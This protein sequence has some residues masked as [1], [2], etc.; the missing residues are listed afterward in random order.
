[1]KVTVL[2]LFLVPIFLINRAQCFL[3]K[4]I[5]QVYCYSE[6]C[7]DILGVPTNATTEEIRSSYHKKMIIANHENDAE[8][9]KRITR[10]FKTLT[11]KRTKKYYDY[12]LEKPNS[13]INIA[14]FYMYFFY[15]A[16]YSLLITLLLLGILSLF[17][18]IHNKLQIRSIVNR[19]L[20]NKTF[21][22]RVNDVIAEKY[23][24]FNT[25][26]N[27]Q[28]SDVLKQI[29]EEVAQEMVLVNGE[30]LKKIKFVDLFIVRFF[31]LP[32]MLY[33]YVIW[34]LKWFVNYK[35]LK[36][37]YNDSDKVYITRK[38]IKYSQTRWDMLDETEKNNYLKKEL[39]KKEN[40]K[41]YIEEQKEIEH[42]KK[43]NSSKYKKELRLRKKK[44][45]YNYND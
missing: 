2:L 17:Q 15:K 8:K 3:H 43:I 22:K 25:W 32:N 34:C 6:N 7:Y 33:A 35:I 26:S 36:M 13:V 31:Y 45:S 20:K 1:M 41:K 19:F 38:Y 29:E 9:K 30:K 4:A 5:K 27:K 12:Y 44:R 18:Y 24:D 39:W 28:Q 37:E 16:F 23:P 42:M 11:N 40:A 14:Y 10:A 21:R